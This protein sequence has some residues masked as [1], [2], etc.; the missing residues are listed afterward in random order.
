[1]A[2]CSDEEVDARSGQYGT[3]FAAMEVV[4]EGDSVGLAARR[5]YM[6]VLAPAPEG[7]AEVHA[8]SA[9]LCAKRTNGRCPPRC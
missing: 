3:H 6:P 1:M 2:L 4:V 9:L 7:V 8:A 5:M